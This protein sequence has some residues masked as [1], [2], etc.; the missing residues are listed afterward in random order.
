LVAH[1]RKL[2]AYRARAFIDLG[3]GLAKLAQRRA[4]LF[5]NQRLR[6]SCLALRL[7]GSVP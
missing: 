5:A 4:A 2:A 1:R 7:L 6:L 3:H